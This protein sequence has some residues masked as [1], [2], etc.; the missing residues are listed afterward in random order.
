MRC[1]KNWVMIIR[2][3]TI[4]YFAV[5]V[6]STVGC[7]T[8]VSNNL[9]Q[10][11]NDQIGID[12]LFNYGNSKQIIA[13]RQKDSEN[14]YDYYCQTGD[15]V[16]AILDNSIAFLPNPSDISSFLS[17]NLDDLIGEDR[18]E[19]GEW[20]LAVILFNHELEIKEV[21]LLQ[22]H[23]DRLGDDIKLFICKAIELTEGHWTKPINNAQY[24]FTIVRCQLF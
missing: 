21:V 20:V 1:Q 22:P 4:I 10:I 14:G 19:L 12:T 23:Q 13:V 7:R 6:I 17:R 9:M 2:F 18:L 3:I 11:N 24:Y 8:C 16:P 15:I 5:N